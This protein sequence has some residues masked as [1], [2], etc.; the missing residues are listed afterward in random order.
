[1]PYQQVPIWD[2][3]DLSSTLCLVIYKKHSK[4]IRANLYRKF[5]IKSLIKF[6]INYEKPFLCH[7]IQHGLYI[8]CWKTTEHRQA[9]IWLNVSV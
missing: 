6:L 2:N 9:P 1:M 5:P 3:L 8:I 7:Q 4:R